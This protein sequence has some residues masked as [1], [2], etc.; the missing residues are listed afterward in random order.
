MANIVGIDGGNFKVKAVGAAGALSFYSNICDWFERGVNEQF[1]ND[2]ME[3][4]INGRQ[5]FAGSIAKIEDEFG[6]G[7]MMG[8]S[9]AHDEAKIRILLALFHY[10]SDGDDIK[11]VVGQPIGQHTPDEKSKIKKMLIGWHDIE[12]NNVKKT[13]FVDEVEI[14][15]EGSAAIWAIEPTNVKTRILDIGSGT[16]NAASITE[17]RKHINTQSTTFNFGAETINNQDFE[18]MA[19]GIIK[20]ASKKWHKNDN[21]LICGGVSEVILPHI[22]KHFTNASLLRPVLNGVELHP[23]YANAVGFY[24]LA[25]MRYK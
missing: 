21:L 11:L 19:R 1:G 17:K 12:V 18:A 6:G 3:F 9:K 4:N 13:I 8:D 15:P 20:N 5:G 10:C 23:M 2:D 16:V 24:K 7:N 25:R 22:K 14:A